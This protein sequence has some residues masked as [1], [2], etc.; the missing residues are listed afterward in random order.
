MD[1]YA[2]RRRAPLSRTP[3]SSGSPGWPVLVLGGLVLVLLMLLGATYQRCL[4]L[5]AAS[6]SSRAALHE[7]RASSLSGQQGLSGGDP[8]SGFFLRPSEPAELLAVRLDRTASELEET[9]ALLAHAEEDVRKCQAR[10][11]DRSEDSACVSE[12]NKLLVKDR[13]R[14]KQIS[15]LQDAMSSASRFALRQRYPSQ[16][17]I[18]VRMKVRI[19]KAGDSVEKDFEGDVIMEMASVDVMPTA[20]NYFLNQVEAGLWDGC[21]F[22]RNAHH[23]LQASPQSPT[24]KGLHR[25][26][27]ELPMQGESIPFQE[28]S[29]D[30]KHVKY[31]IGL[32]GRPGGPDFY[33][34]T[35]DNT[36]NH[37]PG[38]QTS[39]DL[40][41]EADSCFGKVVEGHAV[42]DMMHKAPN[43]GDS[44]NS[45]VDYIEIVSMRV[46]D[47][48][49]SMP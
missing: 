23:V 12:K 24:H 29:D 5:E 46:E 14:Q 26:F 39:Y 27:K 25:R 16:E 11:E 20:V 28:Y 34:S 37:G 2:S 7:L 42:V 48:N 18:R 21:S 30:Y 32:A 49:P 1:A 47:P 10:L 4:E 44:Y 38:G 22:I 45:L 36:R 40:P 9:R 6:L 31:T 41:S 13:A 33:I 3:G 35:V 8:P 15:T 17:R 43:K 19:P